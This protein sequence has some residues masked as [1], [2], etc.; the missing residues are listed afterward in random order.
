MTTPRKRPGYTVQQH[1]RHADS[2]LATC[3]QLFDQ[4]KR[5]RDEIRRIQGEISRVETIKRYPD[6]VADAVQILQTKHAELGEILA[7]IRAAHEIAR[8]LG[9]AAIYAHQEE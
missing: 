8:R 7:D 2:A 4:A 9:T 6:M 3:D 1:L 5:L